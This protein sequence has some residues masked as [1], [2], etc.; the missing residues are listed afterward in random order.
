MC[1]LFM[2]ESISRLIY[3]SVGVVVYDGIRLVSGE[4]NIIVRN[5][6][7]IMIVVR[8]VLLFVVI[9]MVDLM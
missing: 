9:L 3:I 4:K 8:F 1:S 5:I 6:M 7:L 2:L